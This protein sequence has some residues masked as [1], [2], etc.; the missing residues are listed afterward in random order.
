[1]RLIIIQA[2]M[3]LQVRFRHTWSLHEHRLHVALYL[4]R[5]SSQPRSCNRAKAALTRAASS[6]PFR[7][8]LRARLYIAMR[9]DL[10]N[11][12]VVVVASMLKVYHV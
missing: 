12:V 4:C 3:C 2:I 6:L 7:A 8:A 10:F 9:L 5:C 11:G 1:M